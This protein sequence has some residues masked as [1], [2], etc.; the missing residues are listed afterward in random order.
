MLRRFWDYFF[1]GMIKHPSNVKTC[2][3]V[4]DIGGGTFCIRGR[5][6]SVMA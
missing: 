1:A 5:E 2:S 3:G 6:Y 4:L